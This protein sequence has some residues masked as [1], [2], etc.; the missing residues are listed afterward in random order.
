MSRAVKV[1]IQ[2]TDPGYTND[3]SQVTKS[4]SKGGAGDQ[5][6]VDAWET[7]TNG[8]SRNAVVVLKISTGAGPTASFDANGVVTLTA[9]GNGTS[10]FLLVEIASSDPN[11]WTVNLNTSG[12][13]GYKF[14]KGNG[15]AGRPR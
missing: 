13:S 9:S 10:D 5:V 2:S 3:A 11:N 12:G 14:V 1:S 4:K 7:G 15:G 8:Q 6:T